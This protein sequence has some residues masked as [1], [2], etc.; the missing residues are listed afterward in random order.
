ME[1]NNIFC[2]DEEEIK[3]SKCNKILDT[4]SYFVI[5]GKVG[6]VLDYL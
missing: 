6:K 3:C 1:N 2:E 4:D 5:E